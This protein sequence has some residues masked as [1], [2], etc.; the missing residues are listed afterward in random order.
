VVLRQDFVDIGSENGH[1]V[2]DFAIRTKNYRN[3]IATADV[4]GM[5]ALSNMESIKFRVLRETLSFDGGIN[6]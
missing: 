5:V 3:E 1:F 2:T 4:V 6:A